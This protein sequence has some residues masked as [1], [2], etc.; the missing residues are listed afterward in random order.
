M[1][2]PCEHKCHVV[3]PLPPWFLI[4]LGTGDEAFSDQHLTRTLPLSCHHGPTLASVPDVAQ[5]S[6]QG[7]KHVTKTRRERYTS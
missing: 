3:L 5:K 4:E 2:G 7:K 1:W 6:R